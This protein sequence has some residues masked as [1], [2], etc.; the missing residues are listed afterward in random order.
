MKNSFNTQSHIVMI[1][2]LYIDLEASSGRSYKTLS[3]HLREPDEGITHV[4]TFGYVVNDSACMPEAGGMMGVN[5]LAD[6][7]DVSSEHLKRNILPRLAFIKYYAGIPVT[8]VSS[9][10]AAAELYHQQ[11]KKSRCERIGVKYTD[12]TSGS[13]Y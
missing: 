10:Y 11:A 1:G 3:K 8:N 13:L 4:N 6:I 9:A 5:N 12:C 7:F 2:D